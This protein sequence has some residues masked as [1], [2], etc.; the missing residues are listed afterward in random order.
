[1]SD[2]GHMPVAIRTASSPIWVCARSHAPSAKVVDRV[3]PLDAMLLDV[4]G[5]Q[6]RIVGDDVQ[7][8]R[9]GL[10]RHRASDVAEADDAERLTRDV[11]HGRQVLAGPDAALDEPVVQHE[12]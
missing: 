1:M 10:A 5:R 6:V 9:A 7:A 11:A 3:D 12:L 4:P 2:I 8:E